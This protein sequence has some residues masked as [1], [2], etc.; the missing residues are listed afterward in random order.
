ME[1]LKKYYKKIKIR[2][3]MMKMPSVKWKK[4]QV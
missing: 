2:K 1:K 4:N 3:K